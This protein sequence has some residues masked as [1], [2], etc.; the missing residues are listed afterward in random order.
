MFLKASETRGHFVMLVANKE[1]VYSI[2]KNLKK[3]INTSAA[4][5]RIE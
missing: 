3:P 4:K 5:D 1:G 2:L